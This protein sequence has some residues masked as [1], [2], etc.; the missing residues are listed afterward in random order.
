MK[1]SKNERL[2]TLLIILFS[3]SFISL[4]LHVENTVNIPF[5]EAYCATIKNTCK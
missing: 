2:A 4:L 5:A 3:V 1:L